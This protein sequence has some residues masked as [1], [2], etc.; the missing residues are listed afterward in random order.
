MGI[1]LPSIS[2]SFYSW[3]N[4]RGWGGESQGEIY[5]K[6]P[7]MDPKWLLLGFSKS[8]KR[9]LQIVYLR[10]FP[11]LHNFRDLLLGFS[12]SVKR[13]LQIVYLRNFP[14]LHNFMRYIIWHIIW[15]LSYRVSESVVQKLHENCSKQSFFYV[16]CIFHTAFMFVT[17]VLH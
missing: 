9:K 10:N 16:F 13:K 6:P 11:S 17:Y 14:S 12:K 15:G 4:K 3:H 8:V 2:I 5:K 1:F 7:K